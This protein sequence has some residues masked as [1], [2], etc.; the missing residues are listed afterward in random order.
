MKRNRFPNSGFVT[1]ACLLAVCGMT[2]CGPVVAEAAAF[3]GPVAVVASKDAKS[4]YV[5]NADAKQIAVVDVAGRKVTRSIAVPSEPTGMVLSP[6]GK[7]LY[8]TC[9][10]PRSTVCA[11]DV[12]SGKVIASIPAGHTAIGPAISPDGKKLYE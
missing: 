3:L 6:D 5:A 10:A 1:M 12:S 9:A 11:I 4:L 7:T 2:A 8:V